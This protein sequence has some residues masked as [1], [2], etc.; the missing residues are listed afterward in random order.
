M[1]QDLKRIYLK[2][3]LFRLQVELETIQQE[4]KNIHRLKEII[5]LETRIA[6][7]KKR[8]DETRIAEPAAK[9]KKNN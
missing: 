2:F 5:K 1:I 7:Y 4:I 6:E 8:I 9:S 3:R